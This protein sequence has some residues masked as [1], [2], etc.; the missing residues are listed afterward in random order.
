MAITLVQAT[1]NRDDENRAG[2]WLPNPAPPPPPTAARVTPLKQRAADQVLLL[3]GL[4]RPHRVEV[5]NVYRGCRA[6]RLP[7][8]PLCICSYY[9]PAHSVPTPLAH[10]L[11]LT[12]IEPSRQTALCV[13]YFIHTISVNSKENPTQEVR[14]G[15]ILQEREPKFEEVRYRRETFEAYPYLQSSL[16]FLQSCSRNPSPTERQGRQGWG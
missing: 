2:I 13:K 6:C 5:R 14:Q 11:G 7:T 1:T 16:P 10:V 15:L 9:S 12:F 8:S 3:Q 4:P